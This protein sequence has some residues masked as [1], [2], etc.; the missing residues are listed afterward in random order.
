MQDVLFFRLCDGYASLLILVV[1]CWTGGLVLCEL[2]TCS[3]SF[4]W[5]MVKIHLE[6]AM[7]I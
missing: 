1:S 4:G 7:L 3:F 2:S 5:R 6:L